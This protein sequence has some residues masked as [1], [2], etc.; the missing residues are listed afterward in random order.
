MKKG[1]LSILAASLLVVGCQD[2]DDQFSSLESQISALATTVAGLSQ[3]QTKIT[4]LAGT[5]LSLSTT[6]NG[7]GDA[8]DTAVA[9]GLADIQTDIDA[10]NTAVEN[11]ATAEE[12]STLQDAVDASQDD[13]TQ[14]LANSSV[15]SNKIV[16]NSQATAEIYEAMGSA[17]N[18]VANDVEITISEGMD[19]STVQTVV[20]NILN[21]VGDLTYTANASTIA[22]TT[23]N[24]LSSV[25]SITA[26]QGGGYEFKALTSASNIT[27]N[28]TYKSTVDIIHFGALANVTTIQ[29]EDGTPGTIAFDKASE[30]HLTSLTRYPGN[31]LDITIK[32]GGV[33]AMPVLADTKNDGTAVGSTYALSITGPATV[34]LS[35]ITDGTITL[36][37]VANATVSGFIGETV[38]GTGVE[39]LTLTGA[40]ALDISGADELVT[41]NITGA[42]DTDATLSTA[43]TAGPDVAFASQDLTTATVAGVVG[44]VTAASQ[45]NLESLTVSADLN[46]DTLSVTGN[47]D[48]VSLVVTGAKIGNLT[49]EDNTDLEV[50]TLDHTTELASADT[51]ATVSI[52]GNT[53]MTSLTFSA[54]D[55][56]SL[57]LTGNTALTTIDFTGLA[58]AGTSTTATVMIKENGLVASAAKDTY[59]AAAAADVGSYTTSSGMGTLKTY[60][61]ATNAIPSSSGVKVWFDEVESATSQAAANG[62]FADAA[63]TVSYTSGTEIG[64]VVYNVDDS[65]DTKYQTQSWYIAGPAA[66]AG[67]ILPDSAG[68][69][70]SA[71]AI[72]IDYPVSATTTLTYDA[73]DRA[74]VD[75][76]IT[77]FNTTMDKDNFDLTLTANGK[78]EHTFLVTFRDTDGTAGSWTNSGTIYATFGTTTMLISAASVSAA[79]AADD[80]SGDLALARALSDGINDL[81]SFTAT[82]GGAAGYAYVVVGSAE[83]DLNST[84]VTPLAKWSIPT[85]LSVSKTGGTTSWSANATNGETS[86]T[87]SIGAGVARYAGFILTAKNKTSGS[88]RTVAVEGT[89]G[90]FGTVSALSTASFYNDGNIDNDA[91]TTVDSEIGAYIRSY[92]NSDAGTSATDATNRLAWL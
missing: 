70:A 91:A 38:V 89:G 45:A 5:V 24:N 9:D 6:V 37:E 31:D 2:Y 46:G 78:K 74:T 62:A 52:K 66:A 69:D 22:E 84:D 7:L 30:F 76:F 10:I 13:L 43:D 20:D 85:S 40:V 15:Y 44:D 90:Y 68:F 34:N 73:D 17:I 28:N 4:E 59:N 42:L 50:V 57:T 51:G 35:T 61:T 16:I 60:L 48:L 14:L 25:E 23:F 1:L 32:K 54:D 79:T 63:T 72:G 39:N 47:N 8:I 86:Y 55:V 21:I 77:S 29:D 87:L 53:N 58:D 36:T 64:A 27:L 67:G 11:V 12:V 75:A 81:A 82:S 65:V 80:T 26:K 19:Q 49:V 88:D 71:D 83:S 41:A 33:L 3:V 18:I 92:A 56:D